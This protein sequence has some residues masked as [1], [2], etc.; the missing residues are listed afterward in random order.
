M[1]RMNSG[2]KKKNATAQ[3]DAPRASRVLSLTRPR[4]QGCYLQTPLEAPSSLSE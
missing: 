2:T 1:F 4:P 3:L